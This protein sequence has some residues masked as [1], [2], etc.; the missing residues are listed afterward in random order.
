MMI[1]L[2]TTYFDA[3]FLLEESVPVT[4]SLTRLEHLVEELRDD[5]RDELWVRV[6]EE[7][8]GRHQRAAVEV[9]NVLQKGS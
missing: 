7:G 3:S 8:D 9:H 2:E 5:R 4:H 1:Y 6:G